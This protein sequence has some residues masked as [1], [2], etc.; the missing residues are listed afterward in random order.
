VV[1]DRVY[2]LL[3]PLISVK[4]GVASGESRVRRHLARGYQLVTEWRG[5]TH[6]QARDVERQ[7]IAWWRSQGWPQ[8]EAAPKDGRTETTS[9]EHLDATLA[10]IEGLL[11]AKPGQWSQLGLFP[12]A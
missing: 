12:A 7:T 11:V 3:Q 9:S 5:L 8:V 1:F 2:L 4:V 6:T 10:W